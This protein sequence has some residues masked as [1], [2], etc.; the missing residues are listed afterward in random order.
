MKFVHI[1]DL[2]IDSP[3]INLSDKDGFGDLKRLEQRKVLRKIIDY[4]K[5]NNVNYFFISGDLYEHQYVKRSTI[6]YINNL[7]KEIPETHIFISPGNHDPFVKNSY[8]NMFKWNENVHIFS[9]KIEKVEL[10]DIVVYGYGF[11]DFY[12]TDCGIEDLQIDNKEKFNVLVI[13]STIDGANL[14][15]KQYNSISKNILRD[16]EFNY[17]ATGH[18]HKR[19]IFEDP[20]IVYPGSTVSLGFDEMGEHGMIVGQVDNNDIQL[21]FIPLAETEFVENSIDVSDVIS[22]EEL[23]ERINLLEVKENQFVKVLLVGNRNFEISVYEL[24]KLISNDRIIKIKDK[25]KMSYDLESMQNDITLKGLFAK[26]MLKRLNKENI[27]EDDKK[28]IEK[29]VEIGLEALE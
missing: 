13:H 9:S 14:E 29:A 12:C 19:Q 21:S 8:Y 28:I 27:S 24:Y 11:N 5:E 22:K 10:S 7:F 26:E 1:A 15:E 17:V 16:E 4:I 20:C 23:L 25:T 18:I 2:H 6:E 3:F